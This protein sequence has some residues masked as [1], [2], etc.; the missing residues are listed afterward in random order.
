M[1]DTF[2]IAYPTDQRFGEDCVKMLDDIHLE[3]MAIGRTA[4]R[5]GRADSL[6]ESQLV[7]V[8]F[9]YTGDQN[10]PLMERFTFKKAEVVSFS[11]ELAWLSAQ[12]NTEIQVDQLRRAIADRASNTLPMRSKLAGV[13]Y[14]FI[15][16]VFADVMLDAHTMG[17]REQ[18]ESPKQ[19][20]AEAVLRLSDSEAGL[21]S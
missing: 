20:S 21:D 2:N 6:I 11:D 15:A 9:H 7:K 19:L 1:N 18:C 14:T 5:V 10:R 3:L 12:P 17:W 16:V 8:G 4:L 13:W